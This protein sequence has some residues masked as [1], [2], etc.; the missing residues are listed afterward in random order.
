MDGGKNDPQNAYQRERKFFPRPLNGLEICLAALLSPRSVGSA[1]FF[2]YGMARARSSAPDRACSRTPLLPTA[3][4]PGRLSLMNIEWDKLF[5]LSVPFAELVV[6]GT[7]MYLFLWLL[8]RVV[9]KR[10]IGAIGMADLLVLVIIADAAQ[11]GMAGTYTSIT[12]AVVVVG[13]IVLWNLFLDWLAFHFP[14]VQHLLEPAPLVVVD[15][16]RILWRNM[17][18]ELI[19]RAEL[20]AKL[21]EHGVHD[22]A[23][24]EKARVEPDGQISVLKRRAPSTSRQ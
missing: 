10:R 2:S 14:A 12:D 23:E 17:R 4:A 7:A 8:F 5:T 21:R 6:R 1:V 9:I 15:R 20:E 13:T 24:V 3:G 18:V 19:T 16:G 11:N 22:V